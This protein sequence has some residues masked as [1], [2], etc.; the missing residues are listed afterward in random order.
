V[1]LKR[2]HPPLATPP[3]GKMGELIGVNFELETGRGDIL[4]IALVAFLEF[5]PKP[6]IWG[7]N[8]QF[9][10]LKNCR[11][12]SHISGLGRKFKKHYGQVKYIPPSSL[13]LN[14]DPSRSTVSPLGERGGTRFCF[15]SYCMKVST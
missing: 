15:T 8:L 12:T 4:D 5:P 13:Q 6:K 10:D 1:E 9:L 3:R 14:F 11:L 2:V 7:F